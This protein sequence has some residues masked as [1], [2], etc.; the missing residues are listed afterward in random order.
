MS[1]REF[2]ALGT[3]SQVPTRTRNHNGYFLRWDGEGLLFDPGE[4]TQRQMLFA[5]VSA[6]DITRIFITHLHGDHCLGL[7]GILQRLALDGVAHEVELYYPAAGASYVERLKHASAYRQT[8]RVRDVPIEEPGEIFS[9]AALRI[10]AQPLEHSI[11]TLGYRI[12]EPERV[13]MLPE[14]LAALGLHGPAVGQLKA[15]GS[16]RVGDRLVRLE[17]VSTVGRGQRMAFVMDTRLCDG[18]AA[19]AHEVDLLVCEATFLA[20][21]TDEAVAFGHLTATQAA[22]LA[23]RAGAERLVLTHFSQRY[24]TTEPFLLEAQRRHANVVVVQDGDIVEMPRR[25]RFNGSA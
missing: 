20:S 3:A 5:G 11:P 12:E 16:L 14:R 7:P 1:T 17:E 22:E 13:T 8:E 19:L 25:A 18:A 6:S 9:S 4:G 21:E 15:E 24:P 23:Q 2:I 10:T